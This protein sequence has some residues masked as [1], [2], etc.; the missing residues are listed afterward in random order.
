MNKPQQFDRGIEC[1]ASQEPLAS[2]FA[3]HLSKTLS[4]GEIHP[5]ID[6]WKN[7]MNRF[8][9]SRIIVLLLALC[10]APVSIAANGNGNGK[11]EK[12]DVIMVYNSEPDQAEID[13]VKGLGGETRRE[14]RNFDMRVISVP[15]HVVDRLGNGNGVR[16]VAKDAPIES[17]SAA[18]RQTAGAPAAGSANA[19]AVDSNIGIAVLDSGVAAHSDLNV[20]TRLNCTASAVTPSGTFADIFSTASYSNNDGSLSFS[21][22]WVEEND[23][24][25]ASSTSGAMY[26]S[27]GSVYMNNRDGGSLPAIRRTANLAGAS[28]ATLSFDYLGYGAGGLDIVAIEV[29]SDGG[30]SYTTLESL[31]LVG[32]FD[33][34]RR[35]RAG[36]FHQP[37]RSGDGAHAPHPG[38]RRQLPVRT[39]RQRADHL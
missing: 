2:D 35:L 3:P 29:S 16:F 32:N 37:H 11:P 14:F 20:A 36:R 7:A 23:D 26:V 1:P 18:A 8:N 39:L 15:E 10:L 24:G 25:S 34:S 22:N 6:Q 17:F 21:S 33:S 13:R 9:S 27:S 28:S 4:T 5:T 12:V 38:S 30:A 31:E 19:F